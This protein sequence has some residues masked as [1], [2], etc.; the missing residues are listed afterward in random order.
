[1]STLASLAVGESARIESVGG[2]RGYRRRLL[3]LGFLP[4]SVVR[5]RGVAPMGDPLDVDIAGC[6]FSLRRAEAE[7][8]VLSSTAQA[9]PALELA[10]AK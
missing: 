3:E 4:G 7:A 8:V 9:G 10:A 2:E 5:L 1:M 6:R